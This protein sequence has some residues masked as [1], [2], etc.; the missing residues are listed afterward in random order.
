MTLEMNKNDKSLLY[1]LQFRFPLTPRPYLEVAKRLGLSEET[2][3]KRIRAFKRKG[4]IRYI[5]SVFNSR[6]LGFESTLIAMS[7]PQKKLSRT[8]KTINNLRCVSHNYL[9]DDGDFNLW[10][11]LTVPQGKLFAVLKRIK[12]LTGIKKMLNLRSEEVF[13][14]DTRFKV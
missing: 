3:I 13:K 11:T 5:G 1:E 6:K 7:V 2:V 10:F 4:I 8:V 12:R 9:R 14:I